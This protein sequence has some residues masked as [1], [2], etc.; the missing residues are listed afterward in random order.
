ML[1]PSQLLQIDFDQ[2]HRYAAVTVLL[3]PLLAAWHQREHRMLR[4]LEVGSH[5][6]NLLSACLAPLPVEIVRADL[7]P[8]LAGDLGP[9]VTI[10]KDTPL[11]FEDNSFDIVVAMEVLE[12]IPAEDR[13]FAMGEWTRVS[14][15][16]LLFSCPSGKRVGKLEA[17]ADADFQDR[18][19]RVHPWLEEHERFGWPTKAEVETLCETLGLGCRRFHNAPLA[20]WLPLLLATEHLFETGDCELLQ[21]FNAMLNLRPFRAFIREPGYRALYAAMKP[22]QWEAEAKELWQHV[23]EP[24]AVH[25]KLDPTR[26]L[27]QRLTTF[28]KEQRTQQVEAGRLASLERQNRE[29]Q[30]RLEQSTCAQAWDHWCTTYG[31]KKAWTLPQHLTVQDLVPFGP[32]HWLVEGQ[33]PALTWP[34]AY[35]KGWHRLTLRADV[36]QHHAV[37]L[38]PDYGEGFSD[39]HRINFCQ[40]SGKLQQRSVN[41]YFHH[42]VRQLRL[43]FTQASG[44]VVIDAFYVTPQPS[45]KVA[46]AGV[47]KLTS[48]LL[49]HPRQLAAERRQHPSWLHLGMDLTTRDSNAVELTPYQRWL[50]QQRCSPSELQ[51]LRIRYQHQAASMAFF[52]RLTDSA[53]DQAVTE[54]LQNLAAL[55]STR[56]TLWIAAPADRQQIHHPQVQYINDGP[57]RSLASLIND[58]ARQCQAV[59]LMQLEPGDIVEPDLGLQLLEAWRLEPQASYIVMDEDQRLPERGYGLP[60]LKPR[61]QAETLRYQPELVGRALALH[62]PTLVEQGVNPAYEGALWP[63][64]LQR[65]QRARLTGT[66]VRRVVLHQLP[67][68]SPSPAVKLVWERL[69][70]DMSDDCRIEQQRIAIDTSTAAVSP[71]RFRSQSAPGSLISIIIPTAGRVAGDVL[72]LERCLHSIRSLSTFQHM[73]ILVVE[74]GDLSSRAEAAIEQQDARRVTLSG[75]F[76]YSRS[77]NAA[78]QAARGTHFL[79]LNDDTEVLTPDWLER[80]LSMSQQEIGAVGARLLFPNGNLQHVGISLKDGVPMHPYYGKPMQPGYQD[81]CIMPR[82]WLAVTAACLL[83]PRLAFEKLGGFD[84]RYELNYNDVD[85]CLRLWQAGY[86]VMMNPHVELYHHEAMRQDGRA[87]YRPEELQRYADRWRR[88][89]PSDPFLPLPPF[90]EAGIC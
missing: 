55:D 75:R 21:R 77:I 9:Y 81:C 46:L 6:L 14:S 29:F 33:T 44:P 88:E 89:Y 79:L 37:L 22:G 10:E 3:K 54:T 47:V 15:R 36:A 69:C 82:N 83:T 30:L 23:V 31:H 87:A 66:Q 72:H 18:H 90:G 5:S 68:S 85:Y 17:R 41:C 39:V 8:H 61:L 25:R 38:F 28:V 40:W 65:L 27:A 59:W 42:P 32:A 84:E 53:S 56:W 12:H 57:D 62:V 19:G 4:V 52:L 1:L 34:V 70:E 74:H 80:L 48:Q 63:E 16:G 11:P 86:R 64:Y 78:A 60:L 7:E 73:E 26:M 76:N 24:V 49:Q 71:I 45:W 67:V 35:D 51:K 43:L 58:C 2:F 20:E 50:A 13:L